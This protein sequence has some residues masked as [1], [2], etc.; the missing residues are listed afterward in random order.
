MIT[1]KDLKEVSSSLNVLYVEDEE[2][3]REN[4]Q[5]T[6]VKLFA[7]T[8]VAKNGQ[9]AFEIFK[10]EKI[11]I[12]VTDINMPIMGGIEL[13]Q[14]IHKHPE[15]ES[16]I[17]VLSAHDESRLLI[18]LIN[19]GINN[20]VNKPV[21]KQIL[22]NSL[23]QTCKIIS[24]KKLLTKYEFQLQQELEA[25]TR[26]NNIL[27]Q[28]INQLAVQTNQNIQ[29]NNANTAE[30]KKEDQ[31]YFKTILQ[32]D[33][34]ELYDLS[35]DLADYIVILFQSDRLNENYL[36]TLSNVY[37]KYG[38]II[39]TYP[40]F[41]DISNVLYAFSQTILKLEDKFMKDL[42]Q[43]GILFES[44]NMT[45]ENFRRNI[46]MKEAKNPKFYNASLIMDI[47]LVIDFLEDKEVEENEIEFF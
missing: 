7:N 32:D 6:F 29:K 17:M 38:A 15:N 23:Y 45:L 12:V 44:L 11:D 14:Q 39:N 9:E 22:I 33:K 36:P 20:F 34:D 13:I 43:S 25:M 24:D 37:R 18:K 1:A 3:L 40:E 46:I 4:M 27:E 26:K 41:F 42:N 47:Q 21:D 5:N 10:K 8:Y 2:I 16:S 31:D 35:V 30:V 19:L 28:K